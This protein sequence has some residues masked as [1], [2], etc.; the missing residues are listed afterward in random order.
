MSE[1]LGSDNE[2]EDNYYAFLNL[3]KDASIFMSYALLL[4]FNLL[5]SSC[6]II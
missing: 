1:E 4:F 3:P 6:F 2:L 5:I